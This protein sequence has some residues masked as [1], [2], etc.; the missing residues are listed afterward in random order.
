MPPYCTLHPLVAWGAGQG[1]WLCARRS[2]GPKG[3]RGDRQG[4][5]RND[6]VRCPRA[7][8]PPSTAPLLSH[9]L[10]PCVA[11]VQGR[12]PLPI[13]TPPTDPSSPPPRITALISHPSQITELS[14]CFSAANCVSHPPQSH[15]LATALV[16]QGGLRGRVG[17]VAATNAR[18]IGQAGEPPRAKGRRRRS[19]T[20]PPHPSGLHYWNGLGRGQGR[21]AAGWV[22][23]GPSSANPAPGPK[24]HQPPA[25]PRAPLRSLPVCRP[26][27]ASLPSLF[28]SWGTTLGPTSSPS[29]LVHLRHVPVT[30]APM[31]W[32][33][34]QAVSHPIGC[35]AVRSMAS[36]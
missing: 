15:S 33:G 23:V 22:K 14:L 8:P 16:E 9:P 29:E 21:N 12:S 24:V 18:I 25:L 26:D 4:Q 28:C 5:T 1:G 27:L 7:P 31:T 34:A 11:Q 30:H 19:Q 13:Q 2:S 32:P 35:K 36:G 3:L 6:L 20:P 17:G 10:P